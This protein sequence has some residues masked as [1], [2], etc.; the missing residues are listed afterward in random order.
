MSQNADYYLEGAWNLRCQECY[1]KIK[2]TDAYFRWDN[3]WVCSTCWEIRNPQDFVRG[4][5]DNSSIPFS[6]GNPPP[7]Y[8]GTFLENPPNRLFN[9]Y[10]CGSQTMG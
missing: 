10:A 9:S 3:L 7:I 8:I 4:I 5:P 1:K 6:T 2:S